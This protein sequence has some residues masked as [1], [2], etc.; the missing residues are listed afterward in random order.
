MPERLDILDNLLL[1][2][3]KQ[4][5]ATPENFNELYRGVTQH[6][7]KRRHP[8]AAHHFDHRPPIRGS[9][10]FRGQPYF[11]PVPGIHRQRLRLHQP[12]PGRGGAGARRAGGFPEIEKKLLDLHGKAF[13]VER[14]VLLVEGSRLSSKIYMQALSGLPVHTVTMQNGYDA[15]LRALNEPFDILISSLEVTVLNG[16]A[17]IG[18]LRLSSSPSRHIKTILPTSNPELEKHGRRG[19]DANYVIMKNPAL[20]A[21]LH[22]TVGKII[23]GLGSRTR[24]D[25]RHPV[26]ESEETR[27]QHKPHGKRHRQSARLTWKWDQRLASAPQTWCMLKRISA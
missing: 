11:D 19:A 23:A 1:A 2:I 25:K 14:S 8:R 5:G 12:A 21:N 20:A 24:P 7:G 27:R 10:E 26:S 16:R 17:L 9:A 6:Q 13:A 3:E 18:A 4:G 22:A 15:L